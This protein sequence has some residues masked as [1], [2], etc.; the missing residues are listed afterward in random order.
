MK[1]HHFGNPDLDFVANEAISTVS[2]DFSRLGRKIAAAEI[3]SFQA[4]ISKV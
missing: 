3:G 4:E 2:C 1:L